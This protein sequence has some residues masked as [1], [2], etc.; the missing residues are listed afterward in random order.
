MKTWKKILIVIITIFV[1]MIGL[2]VLRFTQGASAAEDIALDYLQSSANVIV[3]DTGWVTF[4]PAGQPTATGFIFYP[5]GNVSYEAYAPTL[6]KIAAQG[7]FVIDVPMPLNLALFGTQKAAEVIAAYPN[8]EHWV[9]GGHS[10]GGAMAARFVSENPG[11]VEGVAFWAAYPAENDSLR[12]TGVRALSIFGT[13]DG[14]ADL[15][16]I[17]NSIPLL[18]AD[19]IW[20]AIEGGNHAQFGYYGEQNGD[21]PAEITREAQQAEIIAVMVN[22]LQT[23]GP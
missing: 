10:L 1:G 13:M 22:F 11:M 20:A 23:F 7:F 14:L 18:P 2:S 16:K 17:E 8:I 6:N 19:T 3:D 12:D 15:Q 5:G 9:I 21:N 4:S